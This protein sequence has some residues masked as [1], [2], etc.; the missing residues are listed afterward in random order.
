MIQ[1]EFSFLLIIQNTAYLWFMDHSD[2]VY[3]LIDWTLD[4]ILKERISGKQGWYN[5]GIR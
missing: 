3:D 5:T 2:E 4:C 1:D